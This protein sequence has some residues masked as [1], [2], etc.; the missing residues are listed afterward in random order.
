MLEYCLGLAWGV[1][2]VGSVVYSLSRSIFPPLGK[3]DVMARTRVIFGIDMFLCF[4]PINS[5]M[6]EHP[7][8][9]GFPILRRYISLR[10]LRQN[11]RICKR[12]I[13]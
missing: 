13:M 2:A 3:F 5:M 7:V 6:R 1:T 12:E 8:H 11:P 9:Q 10:C 4:H